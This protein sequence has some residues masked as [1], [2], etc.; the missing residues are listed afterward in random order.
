MRM[1][2]QSLETYTILW[3]HVFGTQAQDVWDLGPMSSVQ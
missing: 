3:G 1:R 2:T